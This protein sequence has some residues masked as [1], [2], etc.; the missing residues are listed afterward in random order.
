M[1]YLVHVEHA[2]FELELT[3][4]NLGDVEDVIYQ[5]H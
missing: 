4:L 1:E 3:R 2:L 5:V